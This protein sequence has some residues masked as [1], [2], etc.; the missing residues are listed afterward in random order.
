M[1]VNVFR[2]YERDVDLILLEEFMLNRPLL[3]H[4]MAGLGLKADIVDCEGAVSLCDQDG[5]S[6]VV[7]AVTVCG[8]KKP[9]ALM[10]EDKLDACLQPRQAARYRLRGARG[11]AEGRWSGFRTLLCA[12]QA[13]IDNVQGHEDFDG[14]FSLETLAGWMKVSGGEYG[15]YHAMLLEIASARASSPYVRPKDDVTDRVWNDIYHLAHAEFQ[16]LE[17]RPPDFASRQTWL[18]FRP[19]DMAKGIYILC[20]GSDGK[21]DLTFNGVSREDLAHAVSDVLEP[22]MTVHQTGKSAALRLVFSPVD[23]FGFTHLRDEFTP[24]LAQSARL[25]EFYRRYRKRME[26]IATKPL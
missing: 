7:V 8:E 26:R 20:K 16:V 4:V 21:A 22:D 10:I 23:L 17:M 19:Q 3:G 12:P 1:K 13:Y 9:L 18:T 14:F 2:L 11:V 24:M 25:V 5:E 6:D 15:V